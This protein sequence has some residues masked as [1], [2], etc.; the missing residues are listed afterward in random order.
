MAVSASATSASISSLT[1]GV[2]YRFSVTATNAIGTSPESAQS[3][4]VIPA[5]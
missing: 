1:G 4:Q 5:K 3:N 2:P